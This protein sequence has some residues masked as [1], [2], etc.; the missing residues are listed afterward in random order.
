[1]HQEARSEAPIEVLG[2]LERSDI[3]FVLVGPR[4]L[5][6]VRVSLTPVPG[7]DVHRLI[8]G[9]DQERG[10]SLANVA[11]VELEFTVDIGGIT[12]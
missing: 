6:H 1:M 8:G 5:D 7:I 4:V 2:E 12:I 10:I 9:V 3:G 11:V